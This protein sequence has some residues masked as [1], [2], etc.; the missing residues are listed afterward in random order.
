MSPWYVPPHRQLQ[1][2]SGLR[3][4]TGLQAPALSTSRAEIS[5]TAGL[6]AT[7]SGCLLN[8]FSKGVCSAPDLDL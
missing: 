4:H 7:A 1:R 3:R 6:S 5:D 8:G 2:P